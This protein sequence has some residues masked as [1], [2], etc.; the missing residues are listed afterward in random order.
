MKVHRIVKDGHTIACGGS[1]VGL[2][3]QRARVSLEA[4]MARHADAEPC[5]R[6]WR[7][8][9]LIDDSKRRAPLA[10]TDRRYVDECRAAGLDPD[11]TV[12]AWVDHE[13]ATFAAM[14]AQRRR[15]RDLGIDEVIATVIEDD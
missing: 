15:D 1:V 3:A 6:C 11:P 14:Q 12:A 9:V 13:A 10:A 2:H 4:F 5:A 7:A 8:R